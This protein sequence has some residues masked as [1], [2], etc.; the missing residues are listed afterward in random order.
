M[1][2]REEFHAKR[3]EIVSKN[4]PCLGEERRHILIRTPNRQEQKRTSY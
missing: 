2:V 3:R 1:E 4:A